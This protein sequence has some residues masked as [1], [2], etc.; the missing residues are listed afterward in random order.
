MVSF[1]SHRQNF[2]LV[3]FFSFF[4]FLFF[5]FFS[6]LPFSLG[7]ESIFRLYLFFQMRYNIRFGH[8]NKYIQFYAGI[9]YLVNLSRMLYN[10]D[11]HMLYDNTEN[12]TQK[13]L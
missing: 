8:V 11:Y 4:N 9:Q 7:I 6:P 13:L 10:N 2:S 5:N 3:I 1:V 12:I